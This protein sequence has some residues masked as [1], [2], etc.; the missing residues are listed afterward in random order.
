MQA[1]TKPTRRVAAAVS[2]ALLLFTGVGC[3]AEGSDSAD[4][5]TTTAAAS[6][7][8]GDATTTTEATDST[9]EPTQTTEA[10]GSGDLESL[11]PT[12]AD[13]PAGYE[14]TPNS[15][16]DD[17]DEDV[18]KEIEK[19]CPDAA[20]LDKVLDNDDHEDE[21]VKRS[22]AADGGKGIEVELRPANDDDVDVDEVVSALN[23]CD[24]INTTFGQTPATMDIS[25]EALD[26]GEE[27]IRMDIAVAFEDEGTEYHMDMTGFMFRRDGVAAQVSVTSGFDP[28]TGAKV[29]SDADAAE[30][31]ARSIDQAIQDR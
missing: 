15:P 25:A 22:F 3:S 12:A 6:N 14:Q 30:D 26:V 19:A 16:N 31:L 4:S 13:L 1:P 17:G 23:K 10:T 9:T 29:A 7:P 28:S 20:M 5:T 2:V 27:G 18:D 8:K 21:A 11:L 24:T